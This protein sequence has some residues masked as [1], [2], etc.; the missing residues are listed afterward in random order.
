MYGRNYY[1]SVSGI[2]NYLLYIAQ[3]YIINQCKYQIIES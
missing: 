2:Q 1:L 3:A